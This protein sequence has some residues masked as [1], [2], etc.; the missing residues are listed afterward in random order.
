MCLEDMNKLK[1]QKVE[2]LVTIHVRQMQLFKEI[3]ELVKDHK[4]KDSQDFEWT[5]NISHMRFGRMNKRFDAGR[6]TRIL[7]L[8]EMARGE[9]IPDMKREAMLDIKGADEVDLVRSGLEATMEDAYAEM[10]QV[11]RSTPGIG[12]DLRTAAYLVAIRKVVTSYTQLGIFP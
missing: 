5:K 11:Q 1:R 9:K 2:T 6:V 10:K 3:K 12:N 4:L 7:D 8:I